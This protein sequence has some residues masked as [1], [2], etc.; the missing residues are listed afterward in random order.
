LSDY[1]TIKNGYI[2]YKC[3]GYTDVFGTHLRENN[4][5]EIYNGNVDGFKFGMNEKYRS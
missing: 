1:I 3:G 5:N 2:K 4:P